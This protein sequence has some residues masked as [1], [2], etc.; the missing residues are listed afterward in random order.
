[1]LVLGA[2]VIHPAAFCPQANR[3]ADSIG[4]ACALVRSREDAGCA[5]DWLQVAT[6]VRI[7]GSGIALIGA[8]TGD[9]SFETDARLDAGRRQALTKVLA[10]VPAKPAS[11]EIALGVDAFAGAIGTG[12]GARGQIL[13]DAG[14]RH[15]RIRDAGIIRPALGTV[16]Q[17]NI[18]ASLR[19]FRTDRGGAGLFRFLAGDGIAA[20]TIER[21]VT[22]RIAVAITSVV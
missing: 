12:S 11:V 1:M 6:G 7:T 10:D 13:A 22:M 16:V 17:G 19:C 18:L 4:P 15:A 5:G 8:W 2:I 21:A 3:I 9:R 14:S 20:D